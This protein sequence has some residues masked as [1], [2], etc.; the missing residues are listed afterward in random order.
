LASFPSAIRLLSALQKFFF[1][2]IR[3]RLSLNLD[4][5]SVQIT[6]N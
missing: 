1:W 5:S 6:T 2:K 4:K 3:Y